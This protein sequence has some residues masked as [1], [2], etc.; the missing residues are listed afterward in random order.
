MME[1]L[2]SESFAVARYRLA[3][4]WVKDWEPRA[5]VEFLLRSLIDLAAPKNPK[6]PPA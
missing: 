2:P 5:A 3:L 4:Q 6:N 1:G